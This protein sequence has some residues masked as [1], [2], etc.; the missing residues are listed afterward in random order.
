MQLCACYH[1]IKRYSYPLNKHIVE[2]VCWGTKEPETCLC[3]GNE[4]KCDFYPNIRKEAQLCDAIKSEHD[5]TKIIRA[6]VK[7]LQEIART[8]PMGDPGLKV[9]I[10]KLKEVLSNDKKA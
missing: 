5:S 3:E 9:A 10:K 4:S 6:V 1:K 8:Y 2:S 7:L